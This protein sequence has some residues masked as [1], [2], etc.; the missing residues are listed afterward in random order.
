MTTELLRCP[1]AARRLGVS[2][3]R[4]YELIDSGELEY[5]RGPQGWALI[6]VPALERFLEEHRDSGRTQAG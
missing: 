6:P 5:E 2:T 1:E 3:K 4:V